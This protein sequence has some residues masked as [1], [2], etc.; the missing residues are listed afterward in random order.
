LEIQV[1]QNPDHPAPRE[2]EIRA[3]VD[4]MGALNLSAGL[5]LTDANAE[6]VTQNGCTIK[7]RSLAEWL[8]ES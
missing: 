1:A 7:I 3:L 5:I 8:L 4:A 6:S 2:R